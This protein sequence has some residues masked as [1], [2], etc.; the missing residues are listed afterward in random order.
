MCGCVGEVVSAKACDAGKGVCVHERET[1]RV[2][3]QGG[4]FLWAP[5]LCYESDRSSCGE[6]GRP[7]RRHL[8]AP[9]GRRRRAQKKTAAKEASET[10]IEL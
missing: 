5:T 1:T 3:G 9:N 10:A 7:R 4:T 6:G 8:S 2:G